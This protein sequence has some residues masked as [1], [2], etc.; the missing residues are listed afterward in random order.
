MF[1]RKIDSLNFHII[2]NKLA[3]IIK[4]KFFSILRQLKTHLKLID[5]F[6]EYVEHYVKIF[7]FLQLRKTVLLKKT[8]IVEIFK[9][10]Y[11]SRIKL[12][13]FIQTKFE[14]Y[15]LFQQTLNNEKY[16]MHFNSTRQ[17]YVNIDVNKKFE[18][19]AMIYHIKNEYFWRINVKFI[20]FLNQLITS[21][22]TK[23]IDL[24]N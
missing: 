11:V 9:K 15:K 8:P 24:Q 16:L 20:M 14:F 22:E 4:F 12:F 3:V 19:N 21:V 1:E 13:K 18:M 10:I 2:K 23:N 6:R 7:E 17:F 5:Q